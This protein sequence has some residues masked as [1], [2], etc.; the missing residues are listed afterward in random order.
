MSLHSRSIL[1]AA[2]MVCL[3]SASNAQVKLNGFAGYTFQDRF[4]MGGAYN[5]YTFSEGTIGDGAHYGGGFEVEIRKNKSIELF[6]QTQKTEGYLNSGLVDFGPYDVSVHYVMLGGLGYQ[7]F[8][9]V[10]SGYGGINLGVGFMSGDASAT[11]FAVGGKLGLMINMSSTVG[12]K[13]GAQ[14]LSPVQGAG[15]GF[16]FGTGG[17]SAG[18]STYSSI[19]QFAFTG[20]LCIALQGRST[21]GTAPKPV[22]SGYPPPPPPPPPSN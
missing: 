5:G 7:P 17:A 8:S 20:G 6:Y 9:P 16:Y 2:S 14:I 12:L 18:V 11:K 4:N 10:V 3:A 1:L 22:G 13:M 21:A 15:G 19:Y